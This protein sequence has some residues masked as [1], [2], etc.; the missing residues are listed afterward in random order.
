MRH[1]K[2]TFCCRF[3]AN[4]SGHSGRG[5]CP[6]ATAANRQRV[7]CCWAPR[8]PSP[9]AELVPMRAGSPDLDLIKQVEQ[10]ARRALRD[11]FR[12]RSS[13]PA[14]MRARVQ[15]KNGLLSGFG[16]RCCAEIGA[17]ARR[18]LIPQWNRGAGNDRPSRHHERRRRKGHRNAVVQ[19]LAGSC[20]GAAAPGDSGYDDAR[21]VERHDRPPSGADRPLRRR[22]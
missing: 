5:A 14:G 12:W 4:N 21:S 8:D 17:N 18:M 13:H 11:G 2:R 19:H 6:S 10:G 3:A 22:R 15:I 9:F 20:V 7:G 16:I 1:R